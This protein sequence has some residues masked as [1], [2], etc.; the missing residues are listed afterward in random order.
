MRTLLLLLLLHLLLLL[1]LLLSLPPPPR[2]CGTAL[3]FCRVKTGQTVV[4]EAALGAVISYQ[5]PFVLGGSIV[6]TIII[7][8]ITPIITSIIITMTRRGDGL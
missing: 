3:G 7:V 6:S 1:R 5:K 4:C 2:F 8:T